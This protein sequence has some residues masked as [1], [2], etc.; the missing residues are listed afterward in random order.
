MVELR[1][2]EDVEYVSDD[3]AE[4]VRTLQYRVKDNFSGHNDDP[5]WGDWQD[6]P[7]VP[8]EHAQR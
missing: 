4:K 1:W 2:V 6:V 7:V 5:D 8:V 3:M